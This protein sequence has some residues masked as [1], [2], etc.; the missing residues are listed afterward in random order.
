MYTDMSM[1]KFLLVAFCTL[2]LSACGEEDELI[3]FPSGE[4][5]SDCQI[6]GNNS[7]KTE[8]NIERDF[9]SQTVQDL[10]YSDVSNCSGTGTIESDP[11]TSDIRIVFSNEDLG[12]GFSYL[13]NTIQ[14]DGVEKQIFVAFKFENS[15]LYLSAPTESL[16]SDPKKTFKDFIADPDFTANQT[17]TRKDLNRPL[18]RN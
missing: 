3:S 8:L 13:T 2:F 15:R 9:K 11:I 6:D 16:E 17:L 7:K 12:N 1:T 18:S 5:I 14:E 4:Y 10:I